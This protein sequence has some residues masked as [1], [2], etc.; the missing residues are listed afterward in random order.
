MFWKRKRPTRKW[1]QASHTVNLFHAVTIVPGDNA[2]QAVRAIEGQRILSEDAPLLP[3][4]DCANPLKCTCRYRHL[5]D[6]RSESR[7][8]ADV[9]LPPR[10]MANDRRSGHGRR[11]TDG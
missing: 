2:C 3:L 8:D 5:K 7:R 11:I 1:K 6:R 10:T 4:Q 9:G